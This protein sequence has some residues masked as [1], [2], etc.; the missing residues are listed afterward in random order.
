MANLQGE[1]WSVDTARL[2][3]LAIRAS[4]VLRDPAVIG[5]CAIAFGDLRQA[6][7]SMGEAV[8]AATAVWRRTHLVGGISG[9]DSAG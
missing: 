3:R 7:G 6:I 9:I 8:A 5:A 4:A 1:A 2:A